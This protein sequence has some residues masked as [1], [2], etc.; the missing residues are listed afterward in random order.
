VES[1]FGTL[2]YVLAN[3]SWHYTVA[4]ASLEIMQII[5]KSN[6]DAKLIKCNKK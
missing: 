3:C 2:P 4:A 5:L 6:P 1:C